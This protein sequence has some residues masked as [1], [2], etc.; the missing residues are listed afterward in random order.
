[1]MA[2]NAMLL[3]CD[4][5]NVHSH[6]TRYGVD[7]S[8]VGVGRIEVELCEAFSIGTGVLTCEAKFGDEYV[9]CWGETE[10]LHKAWVAGH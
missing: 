6:S 2:V 8:L 1:M 9:F 3:I 5:I 4:A 7:I 10:A